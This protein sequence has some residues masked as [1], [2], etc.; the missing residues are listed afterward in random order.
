MLSRG[1]KDQIYDIFKALPPSVQV[2]PRLKRAA[3]SSRDLAG[4]ASA[5][6]D[7][8]EVASLF[9]SK[10]SK[11]ETENVVGFTF[12]EATL[13]HPLIFVI[14]KKIGRFINATIEVSTDLLYYLR[15]QARNEQQQDGVCCSIG[16]VLSIGRPLLCHHAAGHFGSNVSW[17]VC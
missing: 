5:V 4:L 13:L 10:R 15:C 3:F 17:L 1:F 9:A 8:P 14:Q 6:S 7:Q 16:A 11:I 12:A 2:P